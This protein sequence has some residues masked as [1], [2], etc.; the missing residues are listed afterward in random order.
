MNEIFLNYIEMNINLI[1]KT[2]K[3]ITPLVKLFLKFGFSYKMFDKIIKEVFVS[4]AVKNYGTR[5][6]NT[7]T[8][9]IA[10]MTGLS[11]R[12][13]GNIK[14]NIENDEFTGSGLIPCAEKILNVWLSDEDFTNSNNQPKALIFKGSRNSFTDLVRKTKIDTTPRSAYLE[15]IRLGLIECNVKDQIILQRNELINQNNKELFTTKLEDIF[16]KKIRFT[17]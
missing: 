5:G 13:I 12:E 14:Q 7:N 3:A 10:F 4:V 16:G 2:Q 9:R 15:L 1:K 11:R 6:R 17:D 8:S